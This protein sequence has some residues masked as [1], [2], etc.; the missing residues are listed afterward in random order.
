[1]NDIAAD[2]ARQSAHYATYD[3]NVPAG[4]DEDDYLYDA[5]AEDVMD[6]HITDYDLEV[7]K[8]RSR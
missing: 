7:K 2:N 5:D 6:A 4:P 8:D 3:R 1:M